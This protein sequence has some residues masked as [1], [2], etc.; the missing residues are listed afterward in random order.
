MMHRTPALLQAADLGG[1]YLV[2][3]ILL[4]PNLAIA[5]LWRA[6]IERARPSRTLVAA[7][8]AAPILSAA[9]GVSRMRRVEAMEAAA[10]AVNIG[11]AQGNLPLLVRSDGVLVHRRL[12][13]ELRDK[14]AHLV[15][16]SEGSVPDVF[17]EA[18]YKQDARRI[19]NGLGVPV[20]FGAGVE[21]RDGDRTREMN[22]ALL[23]Y[24]KEYLLPFG[25]FIPFGET[26]PWLYEQSPNSGRLA[27][28][29][30]VAPVV[31]AGH[32]ITVLICYEDILPWY[33]SRAV[34]EGKPELLVNITIDTWFGRT[35]EPWEHLALAQMRAVEHRRFL[36]RATNT[37]VSAIVDAAGRVTTQ[38]G[39]FDEEAFV[40]EVRLMDPSTVYEAV[41][42][43]PWY[44]GALAI[45]A[46]AMSR[47]PR[48]GSVTRDVTA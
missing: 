9:Y 15:V 14:G 45:A 3:A 17:P 21:R 12:T 37:G 2:G 33:V 40:G 11:V 41:G 26:F 10:P 6:R 43:V 13:E 47:R 42:D 18:T 5:E 48:R 23:A 38:G 39:L 36:V 31:L 8:L 34:A 32:P 30:S 20:L 22:T 25:E 44:A 27:P 19:T 7:G 24:D 4:G 29:D 28:G 35:I 1:V 46:M 16:W